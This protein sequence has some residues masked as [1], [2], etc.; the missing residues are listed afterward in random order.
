MKIHKTEYGDLL[1]EPEEMHLSSGETLR[2]PR[3]TWVF[4]WIDE[5]GIGSKIL[6]GVFSSLVKKD[7]IRIE[8]KVGNDDATIHFTDE[9]RR[10][11]KMLNGVE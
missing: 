1:D 8:G 4:A 10:I 6:R 2:I 3:S 11:C 7:L 5:I 9:G